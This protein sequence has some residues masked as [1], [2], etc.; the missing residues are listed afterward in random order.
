MKALERLPGNLVKDESFLGLVFENRNKKYGAYQ[1]RKRGDRRL[2]IGFAIALF[3]V[4]T[5]FSVPLIQASLEAKKQQPI[6]VKEKRVLHYSELSAPPP[7]A[8]EKPPPE[9]VVQIKKEV[10]KFLKPVVKPDEE[11]IEEELIPTV[12]EVETVEV[13]TGNLEGDDSVNLDLD[14]ESFDL[15]EPEPEVVE[16]FL[17]VEVMP[18]FPGGEGEL[19]DY[20][21]K[22]VRYPS[23]AREFNVQGL[24]VSRFVIEA[25]GSITNIEILRGIGAGCDEEAIRV[26]ESMPQ[27]E[28]GVQNGIHVPVMYTL[29]I[30]FIMKERSD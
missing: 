26:I 24:V 25:D 12:E 11:V 16:P 21:K 15:A 28:P 22:N 23:R 29:P 27:W 6:K 14:I 3:I 4:G 19:I 13:G 9:K 20:L 18:Q 7:I 2:I 1:L 30:R 8:L 10:K 17:V 5:A